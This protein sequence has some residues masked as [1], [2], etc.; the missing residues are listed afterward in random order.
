MLSSTNPTKRPFIGTFGPAAGFA[1][2]CLSLG[3]SAFGQDECAT[4][5]VASIGANAFTTAG[6]TPSAEGAVSDALCTGT[7]LDWVATQ[8]D[9]WMQWTPGQEGIA[10][11]STCLTGSYDTSIALYSGTSCGT[12]T[13]IACNGDGTANGACQQFHSE[14]N[15]ITTNAT[16]SYWIRIGGYQGATGAG[17]LQITFTTSQFEACLTSTESCGEV[18]ASG[19]CS[20]LTCC[21]NVCFFFED[22]CTVAWDQACLDIAVSECGIFL[23]SCP[24][25]GPANDCAANATVVLA[26]SVLAYNTTNANTD[27]P[28]Q[29]ECN[30]GESDLPIHKDVW[31]RFTAPANG[32]ATASNCNDGTF[33][34]KIALYDVGDW[35]QFDPQLLPD[36]FMA[37]NEDCADDPLFNSEQTVAVNVGRTYLVRLGG[38]LG[39]N[40]TGNIHI[41]MPDPCTLPAASASE[42]EGCGNSTNPGC[43]EDEVTVLTTP[44]AL[45]TK[46]SGTFWADGDFRD[47]DWYSFTIASSSQVTGN[48]WSSSN[49]VFVLYSGN[50][51][52]GLAQVA[53]GTATSCP[54][55]LEGCLSP[56]DYVLALAIDGFDGTPCGSG[57]FNDYVVEIT[58]APSDCPQLLGTT[59]R[60]PRSGHPDRQR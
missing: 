54:Q 41:T 1:V 44:L 37:C 27:G 60:K 3:T 49:T 32:F 20:D 34:S 10:S 52:T 25:G 39:Q 15:G 4:A 12:K 43:A 47:V 33:D 31:Y 16:D 40:G 38:Y 23:Y 21:E 29:A 8:P 46:T 19:G 24:A 14:I 55:I 50:P 56:G 58:T 36:Y 7:F 59:L 42:G 6:A 26:N 13:L 57:S 9:V 17:S 30:S 5:T 11:F 48:L 2:I 18:H 51:C 22:C 28:N 35:S 45:N 53:T